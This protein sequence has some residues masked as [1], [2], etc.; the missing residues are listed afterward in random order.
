MKQEVAELSG[1]FCRELSSQEEGEGILMLLFCVK[2]NETHGDVYRPLC[3][4]ETLKKQEFE[5]LVQ[6]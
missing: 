4:R 5:P 6:A 1:N 3:H 2:N